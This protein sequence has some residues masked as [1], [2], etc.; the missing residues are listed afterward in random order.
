MLIHAEVFGQLGLHVLGMMQIFLARK[1]PYDDV[2]SV[3]EEL[4]KA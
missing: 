4:D 1:S 2:L 3:V